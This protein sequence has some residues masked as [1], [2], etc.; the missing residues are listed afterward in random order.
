MITYEVKIVPSIYKAVAISQRYKPL[1]QLNSVNSRKSSK[2]MLQ[3]V[4]IKSKWRQMPFLQDTRQKSVDWNSK[5]RDS[6]NQ[7]KLRMMKFQSFQRKIEDL[8]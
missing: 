8:F 4:A 2:G 6:K 7:I 3:T 1:K 5:T